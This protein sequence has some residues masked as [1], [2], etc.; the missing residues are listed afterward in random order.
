MARTPLVSI[1]TGF[2]MVSALA[3]RGPKGLE[4]K[5]CLLAVDGPLAEAGQ[6]HVCDLS[7]QGFLRGHGSRRLQA[8]G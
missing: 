2:R 8:V 6:R 5:P 7:A 1:L 4:S 3:V